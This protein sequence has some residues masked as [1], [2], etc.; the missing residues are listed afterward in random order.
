MFSSS[1]EG[2]K[3]KKKKIKDRK[4]KFIKVK[5]GAQI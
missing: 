2:A 5:A 4:K 3:K 1:T